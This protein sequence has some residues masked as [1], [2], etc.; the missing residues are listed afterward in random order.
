M[1]FSHVSVKKH[2]LLQG[3]AITYLEN[4]SSKGDK[5]GN[6]KQLR[7][8]LIIED[9]GFDLTKNIEWSTL[10]IVSAATCG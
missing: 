9:F 1:Q 10:G 4:D 8:D 7:T 2:L 3:Y 5:L 6:A